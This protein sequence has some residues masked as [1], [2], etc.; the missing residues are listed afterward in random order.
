LQ[1]QQGDSKE[2]LGLTGEESY[3][4]DIDDSLQPRQEVTVTATTP[5][6]QKKQFKT[7][8]RIDTP[9]EVDY[10]RNGGI[11]H[12]VLKRFAVDEG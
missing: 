2:N 3:H 9:I 8:A 4:I 10:Y 11:L 7:I 5:H 1:F 12:T 6:G